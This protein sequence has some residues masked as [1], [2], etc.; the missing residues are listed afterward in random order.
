MTSSNSIRDAVA[1]CCSAFASTR[2]ASLPQTRAWHRYADRVLAAT[3]PSLVALLIGL[4]V[5]AS[6]L[7]KALPGGLAMVPLAAFFFVAGGWCLLNFARSREAHCVVDGFGWTGLAVVSLAAAVAGLDAATAA[8]IAFVVILVVAILFETS[9]ASTAGT[10]AFT[11]TSSGGD[12]P[13]A[14]RG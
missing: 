3:R 10:T 12:D 2:P 11:R 7:S 9:W 6:L 5:L 14:P 8:W 1:D 13:P 4:G